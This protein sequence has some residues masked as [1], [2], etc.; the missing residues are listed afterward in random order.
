M[1]C[2]LRFVT[3]EHF[4]CFWHLIEP[5][6][7]KIV[8]VSR[9]KGASTDLEEKITLRA[10]K[11]APVDE[12]FL[13]LMHLSVGMTLRDLGHRFDIHRTT[14]SRIVITWANFLYNL[15]GVYRP[16]FLSKRTQMLEEDVRE[17]QSIARLRVHV[18]RCIRRVKENKL[19]DTVI[20][21]SI[22][23][24]INQLFSVACFLVNYQNG[25]LVKAWAIQ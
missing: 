19:F 25:S 13:F 15:L 6:T 14:A 7:S 3:Y 4:M 2:V 12:L 23:G 17:T 22:T 18:E 24:S 20:P 5:S 10:K 11:L 9:A 21:L 8:S 16:A 1:A